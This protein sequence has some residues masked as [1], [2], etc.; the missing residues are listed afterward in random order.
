VSDLASGVSFTDSLA[1]YD[2]DSSSWRTSQLSLFGGL[3]EYL[4]T[5]PRA[6]MTQSGIAF[7]RPPLAPLTDETESG[8]WPTPTLPN[9]GRA[10]PEGTTRTGISPDGKKRQVDLSQA[11]KRWPTPTVDDA[12]NVTR[13]SGEFQSL[14]RAVMFPT[15]CAT[16]GDKGGRGELR[17]FVTQTK[18]YRGGRMLPTPTV[19]DAENNGGSSQYERNSLPLN[20][21]V[22]GALNPTWVE[23]LMG[24]PL[25]WT[26]C[27]DSGTRSSRKS[28]SGSSSGSKKPTA[29]RRASEK[30]RDDKPRKPNV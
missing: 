20:A 16:D 11:V 19:Q 7:Q 13:Q 12:N 6:G 5:W 17:G 29:R 23:W 2:R 25:G 18:G 15:P 28:R 26:D 14:T 10:L 9:G 3:V 22:G 8:L 1:S 4:E 24:Y 27:G 21:V 30:A